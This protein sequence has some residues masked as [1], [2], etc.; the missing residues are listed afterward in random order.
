MFSPDDML[1]RQSRMEE[2]RSNWDNLWEQAARRLLPYHDDFNS[3]HSPGDTRTNYQYDAFPGLALNRYAAAMEAGLTPRTA[4]WHYLS[5][6]DD[7]LDDD[8]DVK[9]YTQA[10]NRLLW[11][12]RYS[13]KANFANQNHEVLIMNGAF[14]NGPLFVEDHPE[15]GVSY[16]SVHL[17]QM[18]WMEDGQGFI[19]TF[20]RKHEMTARQMRKRFGDA[21]PEKPAK[22]IEA[23][24]LDEAFEVLHVVMPRE[25]YD[26][27]RLDHMG[28]KYT[29]TY[30]LLDGKEPLRVDSGYHELPYMVARNVT[31]S[32]EIY[33]RGPGIQLLPDIK[34][35]N[36]MKRD[37]I[38]AAN[39]AVD[40]PTLLHDDSILGEF[41]MQPGARNYGG[42]DD[43]GRQM[44]VPFD[45]R[46]RVD[47]GQEMINDVRAQ[48]DDAFLG[49][50]FR[51]LLE[52]PSMTAT[53]ALLIAQQ[54]GQ[55]TS[56]VVGRL[57]SEY[58]GPL[59]RRES[60]ILFRQGKHPP[61]PP[62]LEDYMRQTGERLTIEYESPMTRAARAEEGVA[63]MRTFESLAAW[64][65]IKGPSV[66]RKFDEGKVAD[67]LAEVNGVPQDVLK[68][69][70]QLEAEDEQEAMQNAAAMALQAAP[71][72]AQTAQSLAQMQA[73]AVP[74]GPEV[75]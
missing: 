31:S 51:V 3:K 67:K 30:I 55:M 75:Q 12:N 42:V 53:Q 52:N 71:V 56:P 10:F 66:Y 62:I 41:R 26:P 11:R 46:A 9:A 29:D 61:M 36:E 35:L 16:R 19:D 7:A 38:E 58:L 20:H 28:M 37:V 60:G 4:T 63:I 23:G 39:M 48:I 69:D 32:R 1:R 74:L 22:A 44:A 72:A 13:P 43:N 68:S 47:I 21:L 54:Q 57:Q 50:Y 59:L 6:G 40:P 27:D 73:T 8:D 24:K 25:D 5:T 70:E 2:R 15:G 65:Q 64:A 34:M 14:G 33:A 18:Y 49:V 45:N 17:S